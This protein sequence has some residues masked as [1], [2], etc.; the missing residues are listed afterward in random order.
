MPQIPHLF[1]FKLKVC[2]TR[3]PQV[4]K[5]KESTLWIKI[6]N[7][8]YKYYLLLDFEEDMKT[9][10]VTG[11]GPAP[12]PAPDRRRRVK[13]RSKTPGE[14]PAAPAPAMPGVDD[15]KNPR[16]TP[17]DAGAGPGEILDIFKYP[18]RTPGG[19]PVDTGRPQW[20]LAYV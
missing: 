1:T 8:K 20:F 16:R 11:H 5:Y 4:Q 13:L 3:S 18:R 15:Y 14:P 12:G 19:P 17:G 2:P 9:W 6:L 7:Q 10:V